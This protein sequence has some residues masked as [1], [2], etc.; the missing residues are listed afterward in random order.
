MPQRDAAPNQR[1]R[2]PILR[3]DDRNERWHSRV[4]VLPEDKTVKNRV[5]S[6]LK[7][8]EVLT[9]AD[10]PTSLGAR[11]IQKNSLDDNNNR[12]ITFIDAEG[13]EFDLVAS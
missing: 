11:H 4:A 6:D 10:R 8:A 7:A 3:P 9:D 12:W 1:D 13:N 2:R 5:H